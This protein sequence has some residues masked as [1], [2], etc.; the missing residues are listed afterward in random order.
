MAAVV[1]AGQES[2][3]PLLAQAT[4]VGGAWV[5]LQERERDQVVQIAE[6]ADWSRPEALEL[7]AQLVGER[8]PA[9]DEILPRASQCPQRL[10]LI[11]VGLEHPETMVIGARQFAQHERVEAIG[12]PARGPEARTGGGDLI[13]MQRQQPQPRIQ[14]PLDQQPIRPLDRDQ[15]HL[16]PHQ[17]AA[18]RPQTLLI[19]RERGR[20]QLLARLVL[21]EHVVLLRRPIYTGVIAH[22]GNS[23]SV[24]HFTAPRPGGTVA[25]AYRQALTQGL[26]PVA[27]SR[28]LT[29]AGEGLVLTRPSKGASASGPLPAAVEAH[30]G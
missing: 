13:G 12:L 30:R 17:R 6:Q 18:Q 5:A 19:V 15:R 14:Q 28:H 2:L 22:L 27:A 8:H 9:L 25:G 7:G 3:K 11:A 10:G 20:Q 26:R 24:K 23:S 16:H 21:H 29:T 1:L 4:R